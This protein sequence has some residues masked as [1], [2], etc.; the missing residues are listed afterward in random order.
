MQQR[1]C[2]CGKPVYVYYLFAGKN[3]KTVFWSKRAVCRTKLTSCPHCG[4]PL[5]INAMH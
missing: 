5:D 3:W 4:R 2:D 1:F